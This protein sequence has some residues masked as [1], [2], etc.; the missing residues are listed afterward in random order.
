MGQ[1]L[2]S[3]GDNGDLNTQCVLDVEGEGITSS[4]W[5]RGGYNGDVING[6]FK[7]TWPLIDAFSRKVL[8]DT[9]V[10]AVKDKLGALADNFHMDLKTFSLGDR[11]VE[12]GGLRIDD[13]VQQTSDAN[14]PEMKVLFI[15]TPIVWHAAM[16]AH[17][18]LAS[19]NIGVSRLRLEGDLIM[20]MVGS[21]PKPPLFQGARACFMNAPLIELEYDQKGGAV[22]KLANFGPLNRA[23]LA[24]VTEQVSNKMVVPNRFGVRL[25]PAC[26]IFRIIKPRPI[27]ILKVTFTRAENLLALDAALF[28]RPTSDPMIKVT[29]GAMRFQSQ[30]VKKTTSPV[31][32]FDV[33]VTVDFP[34]EQELK[35]ELLD[36]DTFTSDDSLGTLPPLKVRELIALGPEEAEYDLLDDKGA[37]GQNGR[38]YLKA[39]W[40]PLL[41]T[42]PTAPPSTPTLDDAGDIFVGIYGARRLPAGPPGTKYWVSVQCSHC[43]GLDGKDITKPRLT[44]KA[45]E[46]AAVGISLQ[47]QEQQKRIFNEKR[48]LCKKY[49]MSEDDM[50][51]LLDTELEHVDCEDPLEIVHHDVDWNNA[52]DFFCL[53]PYDAVL[54]IALLCEHPSGQAAGKSDKH[55]K[56]KDAHAGYFTRAKQALS[57]LSNISMNSLRGKAEEMVLWSW[58]Y[59]IADALQ[60]EPKASI[61]LEV[62]NTTTTLHI[63]LSVRALGEISTTIN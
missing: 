9:V 33:M 57:S 11:A 22:N 29:C 37:S 46:K 52:M 4:D 14:H 41:T 12:V 54:D 23:L 26:D 53:H 48:E 8:E 44:Q 3:T 47:D 13:G 51:V 32:D 45:K 17:V 19:V 5:R 7:A 35:V 21:M 10:P 58:Q 25:D 39:E 27:G 16:T 42:R 20:E 1:T 18:S 50:A 61:M 24:A 36:D 40:R 56:G 55:S 2:C 30:T 63:R 38:L 28:Q 60:E 6:L 15:R 59:K 49:K 43:L 62:P 31:F 34:L